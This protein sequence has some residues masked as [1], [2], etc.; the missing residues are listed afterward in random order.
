MKTH[1]TPQQFVD[2]LDHAQPFESQ[3]HLAECEAC[4]TELAS[5]RALMGDA[6]LASAVPEPSPL[7]WDFLS[8][9]VREAVRVEPV[10]ALPWTARWRMPAVAA[11]VL[12]VIVIATLLRP[13][14]DSRAGMAVP[15][16]VLREA[17]AASAA[18]A[19]A[20]AVWDMIASVAPSMPADTAADSGFRPGP[21][22]TGAAIE[23]LTNAER[24]ALVKLL[25][26]AMKT[27]GAHE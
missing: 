27:S 9:R 21:A 24:Q 2:A 25:Q 3:P 26:D 7:F 8:A 16:D 13:S 15:A 10:P 19:E 18:D 5:M 14:V 20:D 1:L 23:S 11:G 22:V 6:A 12:G 17:T 4:T